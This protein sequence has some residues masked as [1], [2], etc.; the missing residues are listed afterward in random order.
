L[1]KAAPKTSVILKRIWWLI[2]RHRERGVAI[3]LPGLKR[4]VEGLSGK[5]D[6]HGATRLAM[7]VDEPPEW[8]L[9]SL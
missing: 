5:M 3:H 4:N 9:N 6:R 7:T 2:R 1:K 8:L